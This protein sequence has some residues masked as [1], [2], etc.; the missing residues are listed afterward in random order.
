MGSKT[1]QR[2][3]ARF[4]LVD[5]L[6]KAARTAATGAALALLL[7]SCEGE[8]R[9]YVAPMQQDASSNTRSLLPPPGVVA[10]GVA[11][12]GSSEAPDVV[13][14][15]MSENPGQLPLDTPSTAG[16]ATSGDADGSTETALGPLGAS[17]VLAADCVSG[18][19]AAGVD[20]GGRCCDSACNGN[21]CERCS[22]DGTCGALPTFAR[23]CPEVTCPPD[24]VCQDFA[25]SIA[26]GTCQDTTRCAAVSDCGFTW[27]PAA[28]EGQA[29]ACDDDSCTLL[30]REPCTRDADCASGA[31]RPTLAGKSLCCAQACGPGQVCREDGSG[32]DLEP[33]CTNGQTRCSSSSFQ[34][35]VGG[36]WSTQRECG[37]LGCDLAVGGCRRSA[38]EACTGSADCGEGACRATAAGAR[39]CCTA[40]CD[41]S[42]KLCAPSGVSC[43]QLTDDAACGNISCP[44]S[45]TCRTFPPTVTTN[46]CIAGS[47]GSPDAVCPGTARNAG[48]SCSATL[49]CDEVGN[50]AVP[51]EERSLGQSCG[52]NNQICGQGS[53]IGGRCCLAGC[54][55]GCLAD[56]TCNCPTGATLQSGSCVCGPRLNLCTNG[57][58]TTCNNNFFGFEDGSTQG[59]EAFSGTVSA[60]P[61]VCGDA[62]ASCLLGNGVTVV[63][64]P[65]SHGG[66][67]VATAS[68]SLAPGSAR[69]LSMVVGLCGARGSTGTTN[70]AGQ[71]ISAFMNTGSQGG[72]FAGNMFSIAISDGHNPVII[73]M[74]D[75]STVATGGQSTGFRQVSGVVPNSDLGRAVR[76]VILSLELGPAQDTLSFSVDDVQLGD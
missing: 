44:A 20:G 65:V 28:R 55:N 6:W 43:Q 18:F 34:T 13:P 36:Q 1:E 3:R 4:H 66:S 58:V 19:C 30:T 41:T 50:C 22:A 32:C 74:T 45:T 71:T 63:S 9:N 17:C 56:G 70:L 49:L 51:K 2:S 29:C 25:Q 62:F 60:G 35:C 11:G 52:Q 31:C 38:G 27:K 23:D 76:E 61:A 8:H 42:C 24:N 46:R 72:S 10:E 75:A 14:A 37:T 21:P 12:G 33:V 67:F 48:S 5:D 69:R 53:C 16:I 68:G 7:T 40:A 73:G 15:S 26:S 54:P 39:V 64:T 57:S 47:C 59:W